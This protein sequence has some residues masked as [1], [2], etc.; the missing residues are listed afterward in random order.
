[1][2]KTRVL[3]NFTP[4]DF[5]G[6]GMARWKVQSGDGFNQCGRR[7][8]GRP[9]TLVLGSQRRAEDPWL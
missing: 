7:L 2:R 6:G 8:G 5:W 3:L 4:M 9:L 1:M